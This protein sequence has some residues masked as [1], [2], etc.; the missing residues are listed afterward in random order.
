MSAG[1]VRV[2]AGRSDQGNQCGPERRRDMTVAAG[3]QAQDMFDLT[4]PEKTE[5]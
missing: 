3:A 5:T 2:W 1:L 4:P